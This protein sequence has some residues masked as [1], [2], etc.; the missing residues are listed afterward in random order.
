MFSKD[1]NEQQRPDLL[2]N[3]KKDA[4]ETYQPR[5]SPPLR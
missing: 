5:S 4:W 2:K 3:A 1:M